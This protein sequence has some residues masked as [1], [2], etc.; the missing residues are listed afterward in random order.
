MENHENTDTTTPKAVRTPSADDD[1]V[2]TTSTESET[3]GT[4]TLVTD[5]NK[6]Q[7]LIIGAP[8][9]GAVSVPEKYKD[10][11]RA[12]EELQQQNENDETAETEAEDTAE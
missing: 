2:I 10:T 11:E 6:R 7:Q 1:D 8:A 9:L 4:W 5:K 3:F 12:V